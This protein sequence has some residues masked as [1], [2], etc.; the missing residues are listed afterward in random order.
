MC[1]SVESSEVIGGLVEWLRFRAIR[2][3]ECENEVELMFE[4]G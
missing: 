2:A 1:L 3:N 4:G